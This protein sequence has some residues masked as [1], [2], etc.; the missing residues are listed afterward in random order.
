MGGYYADRTDR[1]KFEEKPRCRPYGPFLILLR[2]LQGAYRPLGTR[3]RFLEG[4]YS[5]YDRSEGFPNGIFHPCALWARA[6]A[7]WDK[8]RRVVVAVAAVAVGVTW[9]FRHPKYK[10]RHPKYSGIS[11]DTQ[12]I[13]SDTQSTAIFPG[14]IPNQHD[15][16]FSI[17]R[18]NTKST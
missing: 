10:F 13:S 12:S 18:F 7:R 1:I 15:G 11:S 3:L 17:P 4:L 2:L 6:L 14:S 8:C 16:I 5:P 9:K